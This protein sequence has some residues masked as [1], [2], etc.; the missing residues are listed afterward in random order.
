MG[1]WK[2]EVFRFSC[3]MAAPVAAFYLYHQSDYVR[4]QGLRIGRKVYTDKVRKNQLELEE[5]K[6]D[7]EKI[8][9]NKQKLELEQ[10]DVE[11]KKDKIVCN[12]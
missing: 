12:E 3:Y 1:G 6:R 11:K 7:M 5:F 9:R 2:L 10:L 8:M 4:E